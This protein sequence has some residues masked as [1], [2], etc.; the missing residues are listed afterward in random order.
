MAEALCM[1]SAG[2][3]ITKADPWP[4]SFL[5]NGS[6]P[7]QVQLVAVWQELCQSDLSLDRQ[8]T[9]LYDTLLGTWHTQLQWAAQVQCQALLLGGDGAGHPLNSHTALK[10]SWL[11]TLSSTLGLPGAGW[12]LQPSCCSWSS[13]ADWM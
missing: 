11:L 4:V 3:G 8:L 13:P 2:F 6:V 5:L 10:S 1:G 9:E 12:G 7:H